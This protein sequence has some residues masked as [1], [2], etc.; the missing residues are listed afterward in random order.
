[1]D[2][3]GLSRSAL[4][5]ASLVFLAQGPAG[6]ADHVYQGATKCKMCHHTKAQGEQYPIWQAS[7]HAK[8][9]ETLASDKAKAIGKKL[10]IADPQ[11]DDKCLGCHVTG[12]GAKAD[13]LGP[14]YDATEGVTCESCHG[15]GGD[16]DK[17]S[18]MEGVMKGTIK[19]ETVGLTLPDAKTCEGCHNDKSPTFTSFDFDKMKAKIA[20]PIPAERK[21]KYQ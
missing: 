20:H 3:T 5:A 7:P 8:A 2:L 14:K 4:I 12:H 1:M 13:L 19:P 16:Y 18:T 21:A 15:A 11:K 6:A 9:Y 17:K 10:G